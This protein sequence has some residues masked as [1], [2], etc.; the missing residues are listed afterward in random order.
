M[1][2]KKFNSFYICKNIKVDSVSIIIDQAVFQIIIYRD[3]PVWMRRLIFLT[4]ISG[5]HI[6]INDRNPSRRYPA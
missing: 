3:S 4:M 2:V 5:M 6:T 1:I